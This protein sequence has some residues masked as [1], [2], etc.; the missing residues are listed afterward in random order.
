MFVTWQDEENWINWKTIQI[1]EKD[2]MV[3]TGDPVVQVLEVDEP[4]Q[5]SSNKK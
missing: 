2:S 1:D 3:K 4:E 5:E